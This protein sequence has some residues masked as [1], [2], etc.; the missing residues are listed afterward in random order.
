[1][2]KFFIDVETTGTDHNKHALVQ[3]S[4]I[5]EIDGEEKE[6]VDLNSRPMKGQFVSQEALKVIGKTTQ[7]LRAYP[8]ASETY[9]IFTEIMGN[10]ID[11]FDR[12]DKFWFIG[13]NSRFD[14]G[15]VRRW[16]GLNGDEY[17]G[18]WFYWPAID[19]TNLA[20]IHFM[21]NGGRPDS[22]KLMSVASALGIEVDENKAHDAMY[23][24]E[25]TRD[26]YNKLTRKDNE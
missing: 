17:F 11:K 6:R 10:Y 4:G 25:I 9:R 18:S 20:A 1:M 14:E 13:Y 2:K 3:I 22:F 15:F 8:E 16:F 12:T 23:D 19:V 7:E 24:I 5:I 21:H 26:I